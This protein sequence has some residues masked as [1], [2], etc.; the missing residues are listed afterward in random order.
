MEGL[1]VKINAHSNARSSSYVGKI[2]TELPPITPKPEPRTNSFPS[3]QFSTTNPF[4][5]SLPPASP[6]LGR[7]PRP[8]RVSLLA[9]KAHKLATTGSFSSQDRLF[10]QIIRRANPQELNTIV[11]RFDLVEF[12]TYA[13]KSQRVAALSQQ[14]NAITPAIKARILT[15][16]YDQSSCRNEQLACRLIESLS[17]SDIRSFKEEFEKKLNGISMTRALK[18]IVGRKKLSQILQKIEDTIPADCKVEHRVFSDVD[19]TLYSGW[20]DFRYPKGTIYPGS[21]EFL[22][23]LR[24]TDTTHSANGLGISFLTARPDDGFGFMDQHTRKTMQ[25]AGL[26]SATMLLGDIFHVFPKSRVEKKKVK[27]FKDYARLYPEA[28]FSFVGDSGQQD[29]QVGLRMLQEFPERIRGV[30]VH[31]VTEVSPE[32]QEHLF[33]QGIWHFDNYAD[34]ARIAL[35]KGLISAEQAESIGAAAMRQFYDIQFTDLSQK[36]ALLKDLRSSCHRLSNSVT[37]AKQNSLPLYFQ[38]AS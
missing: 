29:T 15:T 30:F 28:S 38:K 25:K 4:T 8:P 11:G 23:A 2:H 31:N 33:D 35:D 5:S 27:N 16:I 37:H 9:K 13:E 7:L 32:I 6:I 1:D 17:P 26:G 14:A 24:Q 10:A 21:S 12:L 3:S 18:Y 36:E 19:D 22:R 20:R 34:A